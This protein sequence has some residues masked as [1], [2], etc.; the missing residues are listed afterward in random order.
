[1]WFGSDYVHESLFKVFRENQKEHLILIPAVRDDPPHKFSHVRFQNGTLCRWNRPLLGSDYDGHVHLRIEHRVAPAGPTIEDSIANSA[2]YF[3]LVRG[4]S[5]QARRI[6]EMLPFE[7]ARE[8]FYTAARYGM[9]AR[10]PTGNGLVEVPLRTL[11]FHT[12]LPLARRGLEAQEIPADEIDRYIG[13]IEA[14][15]DSGQ[16][17]ANWQRRWVEQHGGNLHNLVTAYRLRQDTG[18]P[19]HTWD[20]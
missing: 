15:I 17:G 8:N 1:M 16:N 12:L 4:L 2:L 18:T 6:D 3:G 10:W 20:F 9:N 19:V 5:E 13:V 14:R 11:M 7:T